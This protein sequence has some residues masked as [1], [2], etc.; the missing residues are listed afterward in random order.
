MRVM[1]EA[2]VFQKE[3][4]KTQNLVP[5]HLTDLFGV[6]NC[7]FTDPIWTIRI[8]TDHLLPKR[9]MEHRPCEKTVWDGLNGEIR[10][11]VATCCHMLFEV[12]FHIVNA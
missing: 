5:D 8:L 4:R 7:N 2:L 11:H 3:F 6:Q 12:Y 1:S 10:P 9:A